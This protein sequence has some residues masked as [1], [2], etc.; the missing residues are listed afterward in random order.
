MNRILV[1]CGVLISL[2]TSAFAQGLNLTWKD[3][4]LESNDQDINFTNCATPD[5]EPIRLYLVLKTP[6]PLPNFIA[7][8][9]IIDLQ[10]QAPGLSPYWRFDAACNEDG[11]K[12]ENDPNLGS[13]GKCAG[14]VNPWGPGGAEATPW[15]VV[16]HPGFGAANRNRMIMAVNRE[17]ASPFPLEPGINYFIAALAF[18]TRYGSACP[19]CD[20]PVAM[21]WNDA[22]LA[23][24]TGNRVH[25]SGPDKIGPCVTVNKALGMQVCQAVP[26]KATAWSRL[27]SIYR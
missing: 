8:Q 5:A 17:S 18:N 14:E 16:T 13:L 7:V 11:I 26:V 12:A 2:S 1:I 27:K 10:Q 20:A 6:A 21:V 4:V 23:E 19:G 25:L 24:N 9:T 22:E 3:C 15:I